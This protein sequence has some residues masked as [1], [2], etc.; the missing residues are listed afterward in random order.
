MS[1]VVIPFQ[2]TTTFDDDEI[3]GGRPIA[4]DLP[5]P[6]T[7]GLSQDSLRVLRRVRTDSLRS[8]R[9]RTSRRQPALVGL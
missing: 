9:R 3:N 5:L 4:F 7:A 2:A 8:A 6:D 1:N